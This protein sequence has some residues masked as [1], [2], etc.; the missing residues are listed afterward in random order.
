MDEGLATYTT[1]A[2]MAE[3]YPDR[4][5]AAISYFGGLVRWPYE[6]VHWSRAVDGDGANAYR[7]TQ[8]TEVPATPSWR[9]NPS[10]GPMTTYF[11]TSL[12]MHTLERLIGWESMQRVLRTFYERTAFTHPTPDVFFAVAEEVSGQDLDW[13][14]DTVHHQANTFDYA[15]GEVRSLV[16]DGGAFDNDIVVK[17]LGSGTFPIDVRVSFENGDSVTERWDGREPWHALRY[18]RASRVTRVEV[19]PGQILRLDLEQTN[20]SWTSEPRAA[21]AAGKWTARWWTWLQHQL[22]TYAFFV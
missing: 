2:L 1:S 19:D 3:A 18:R 4:F 9:Y 21:A 22:L 5:R 16:T 12:W 15:V 17:R 8:G 11:R 20:N 10:T 13:F 6:D 7:Y 14:F